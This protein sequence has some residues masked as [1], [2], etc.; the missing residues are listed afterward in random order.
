[1]RDELVPDRL[2]QCDTEFGDSVVIV[3]DGNHLLFDIANPDNQFRSHW[4]R[5]DAI[6]IATAILQEAT[7]RVNYGQYRQEVTGG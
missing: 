1:M 6:A 2:F 7:G 5:E 4:N 3:R